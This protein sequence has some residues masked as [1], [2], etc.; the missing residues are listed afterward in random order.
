MTTPAAA[1]AVTT[2][3]DR[4]SAWIERERQNGL[5]DIKFC[6]STSTRS[7]VEQFSREFLAIADAIDSK[8]V[9]PVE[10]ASELD[11]NRK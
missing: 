10:I 4:A 5:V 8:Q 9:V 1:Q 7:T 11:G 2:A 6:S 3:I